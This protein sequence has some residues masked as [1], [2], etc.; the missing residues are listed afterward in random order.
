MYVC[1][2]RRGFLDRLTEHII[3]TALTWMVLTPL[4]IFQSL[5]S[6]RDSNFSTST[7]SSVHPTATETFMPVLVVLALGFLASMAYALTTKSSYQVAACMFVC[8]HVC[9]Y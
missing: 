6:V 2:Y 7:S 3:V 8:L 9:M 1:R 5:L 4:V